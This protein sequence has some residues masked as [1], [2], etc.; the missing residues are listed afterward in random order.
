MKKIYF[1][2]LFVSIFAISTKAQV[3][4][5]SEEAPTPGAI[6]ELK[7]DTLGF[8]PPRVQLDSLN[9]PAPLKT[10]VKG[11]VVYNL[12]VDPKRNLQE[13]L[14][15]NNGSRWERLMSS[16]YGESNWFYLPSFPL[17]VTPTAGDDKHIAQLYDQLELQ[18]CDAPGEGS[19][20][21]VASDPNAP[22]ILP[23]KLG[24]A[25]YYFYVTG[26]DDTVFSDVTVDSN[27]W[28]SYKVIGDATDATYMNIVVVVK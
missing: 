22:L 19:S 12:T 20:L 17:D 23:A 8:L 3:T 16:R 26:Y 21:V 9:L 5:G 27:G 24:G 2:L 6:L 18:L 15:S 7:S 1:L 13:G 14:Y 25:G 11:V 28:L 4:I 10:H